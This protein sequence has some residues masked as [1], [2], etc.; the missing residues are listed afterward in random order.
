MHY[1]KPEVAKVLE[2]NIS[3]SDRTMAFTKIRN[4]ASFNHNCGVLAAGKGELIVARRSQVKRDVTDYMPCCHCFEFFVSDEL[5]RHAKKCPF[6]PSHNDVDQHRGCLTSSRILLDEAIVAKDGNLSKEFVRHV[7]SRMYR[8][9][10]ASTVKADNLILHFGSVLFRKLGPCRSLD[11][12]Q[13]LRQL[14]RLL[15]EVRKQCN[16]CVSLTQVLHGKYFDPLLTATEK[17]CS[18]TIDEHRRHSFENPSI[19]LKVG[20]SLLKCAHLKKGLALRQSDTSMATEAD[21]F[22][23][24]HKAE[25]ND[26]ISNRALTSLQLRKMNKAVELPSTEDLV[27]FKDFLNDAINSCVSQLSVA[28]DYSVWRYLS[29]LVLCSLIVFNMR[30]GGETSMLLLDAYINRPNWKSTGIEEI[31]ASLSALE[32]Q[33]L[34]R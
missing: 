13:R 17:L 29:E 15:N 11:I 22:I 16:E 24:L 20:Y 18:V 33:L 28:Y 10:V 12:T 14:G 3:K 26:T 27:K 31:K 2:A 19:G 9:E 5:W 23:A 8:D 21:T 6:N 32:I 30:R 34:N 7:L 25:W 4:I 1:D